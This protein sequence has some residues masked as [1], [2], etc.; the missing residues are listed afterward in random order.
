MFFNGER[1]VGKQSVQF[2]LSRKLGPSVG[3]EKRRIWGRRIARGLIWEGS[4]E[5][6]WLYAS[7]GGYSIDCGILA[8]I[9]NNRGGRVN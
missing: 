2:I 5:R 9:R 1:R 8:T 6:A 4:G 7:F 3:G